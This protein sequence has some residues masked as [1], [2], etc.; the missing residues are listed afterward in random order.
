MNKELKKDEI[1]I[2]DGKYPKIK[3]S[4]MGVNRYIVVQKIF[5]TCKEFNGTTVDKNTG[6][7]KAFTSYSTKVRYNG[8]EVYMSVSPKKVEEFDKLPINTDIRVEK[9]KPEGYE[10][11]FYT[12]ELAEYVESDTISNTNN[13]SDKYTRIK[14]DLDKGLLKPDT[15]I[16]LNGVTMSVSDA[17]NKLSN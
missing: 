9:V 11:A 8:Q 4:D 3:P 14:S 12:Y 17:L 13:V 15:M 7:Q 10:Y 6:K 2:Y 1:E 5:Q 16:E